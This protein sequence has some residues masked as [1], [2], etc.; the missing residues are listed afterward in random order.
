VQV[1][2]GFKKYPAKELQIKQV[3]YV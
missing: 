1:E 2:S 3:E